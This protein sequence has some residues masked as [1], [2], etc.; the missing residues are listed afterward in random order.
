[1][2]EHQMEGSACGR[3]V[4]GIILQDGEEIDR[5]LIEDRMEASQ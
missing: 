3:Y 2:M 4:Y 5:Y 1:M